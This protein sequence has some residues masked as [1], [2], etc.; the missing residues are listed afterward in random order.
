MARKVIPASQT[1]RPAPTRRRSRSLAGRRAGGPARGAWTTTAPQ[2][3]V[4]VDDDPGA[5]P[6]GRPTMTWVLVT[7]ADGRTRPEAH[8]L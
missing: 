7:D 3:P 5:L 6:S 4:T 2:P 8:W 1:S